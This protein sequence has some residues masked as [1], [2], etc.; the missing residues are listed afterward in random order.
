MISFVRFITGN[1]LLLALFVGAVVAQSEPR[2]NEIEIRGLL[3]VPSGEANYSG[4]GDPGSTID[5]NRDFDFKNELGL[6]IRYTHRSKNDKHKVVANY[7]S[8]SWDR[9][10]LFTRSFTFR[11]ETYVANANIDGDLKLRTLRAMYA[12]RWGNDKVRIGPMVDMGLIHVDLN[13]V[14]TTNNGTRSTE[15]SISRFTATVG[16]DLDFNPTPKVNIFNNL[17][18]IAFQND[19]LF[20]TEGGVKYFPATHV[21]V[22]GGYRYQRYKFVN[23]DNFLRITAQGPFFGGVYHF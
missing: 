13:L 9:S 8:S 16:Y 7:E 23:D 2:R 20:H 11:G 14:G 19:R 17:G 21:G 10:T 6:Q 15:G 5:F 4:S 22:V 3:S 1:S 18:A 12:Y